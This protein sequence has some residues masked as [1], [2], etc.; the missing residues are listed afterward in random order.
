MQWW[1]YATRTLDSQAEFWALWNFRPR[2]PGTGPTTRPDDRAQRAGRIF[3][4]RSCSMVSSHCRSRSRSSVWVLLLW[5]QGP[6]S[7]LMYP[8]EQDARP[9]PRAEATDSAPEVSTLLT[10]K[11]L[12]LKHALRWDFQRR[13]W[14][15]GNT[16]PQFVVAIGNP[17]LVLHYSNACLPFHITFSSSVC[18]LAWWVCNWRCL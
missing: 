3:S 7:R 4:A 2:P 14:D 1:T 11:V 16:L 10:P 15:S 17:W 9:W 18:T 13:G 5:A 6:E 8:P 12:S